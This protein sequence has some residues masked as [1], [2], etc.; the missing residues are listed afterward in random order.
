[1]EQMTTVTKVS[2]F[3]DEDDDLEEFKE[4][5]KLIRKMFDIS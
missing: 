2:K 3:V 4:N 5:G 1:M